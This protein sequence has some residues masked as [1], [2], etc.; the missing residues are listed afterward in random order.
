MVTTSIPGEAPA[1]PGSP[2]FDDDQV[3]LFGNGGNGE[4]PSDETLDQ[5]EAEALECVAC[6]LH[7]G[8]NKVVF[9]TGNSCARLMFIGEGPG[10]DEDLQGEPFVGRAGKLLT[11][12]IE[13]MGCR[14][15]DVYIA[16][17]VKCRPPQNRNPQA[18]EMSACEHFLLRQ[19]AV[20]RP[21]IVVLLGRVAVQAILQSSA[22]MSRLR[23][24]FQ[25]W[26][27]IPVMC[28]YHPAY[29]LRNPNAKK[30]VWED[31]QI[32]RDA[33]AEGSE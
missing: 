29:L 4:S 33:L 24:K 25:K 13:A 18:D 16:N 19:I 5:I 20:I 11:K 22:P 9:G 2:L 15:A 10:R 8:R 7:E 21:Q 30:D 1:K 23:G 12:I 31:M 3:G 14:R 17:V 28:T 32:V 6:K 27:G 26:R